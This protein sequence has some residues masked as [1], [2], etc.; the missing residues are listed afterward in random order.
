MA[1]IATGIVL[2]VDPAGATGQ[3][4]V[5]ETGEIL[6]FNDPN[7]PNTGLSPTPPNNA[8]TFEVDQSPP[9]PGQPAQYFATN[10]AV[11]PASNIQIIDKSVAQDIT[12]SRGQ[13]FKITKGATLT[14]SVIINGGKVVVDQNSTINGSIN[15]NS[16][17][18]MVAKS[19]GQVMGN[20]GVI[21]NSGGSLKVVGGGK[22][23]NGSIIIN[24]AGRMIVGDNSGPGAIS[25]T[26]N[27]TGIRGI[28]V[29]DN[30]TI[31]G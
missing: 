24:G 5:D 3:V 28:K 21:I 18:I 31:S 30:S 7:F 25:G 13:V 4:Q 26:M 29:A 23:N 11:A 27:I 15:V 19:G 6:L 20:G 9:Q 2:S 12:A 14:G 10:L 8:C 22:V 17:G 1:D 16:G